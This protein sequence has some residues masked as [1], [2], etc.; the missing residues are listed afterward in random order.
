MLHLNNLK[1]GKRLALGFG[2]AAVMMVV[3]T[4]LALHCITV[5]KTGMDNSLAE[6][7]KMRLI[8]HLE[9]SVGEAYLSLWNLVIDADAD[10]KAAHKTALEKAR[11][12]YLKDLADLNAAAKTSEDRRLLGDLESALTAAREVNTRVLNLSLQGSTAAANTLA[13]GEA[14]RARTK[15]GEVVAEI[16]RW[17]EKRI[18][19]MNTAA[20]AV[21]AGAR[22]QLT[23]GAGAA[24][25]L[26]FIFGTIITRS[27]SH[28][29]SVSVGL[30]GRVGRAMSRKTCRPSCA[31][32]KM[33]W[34]PWPARCSP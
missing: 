11:D 7:S 3:G 28:P 19:D 25:L 10:G 9:A 31:P 15:L 6:A 34:A 17:R 24:V 32:G 27:V 2:A 23:A 16:I 20:E 8:Q 1:I 33:N 21:L 4:I 5:L 29:L 13:V 30:V 12:H 22:L 26:A 14:D 18:K